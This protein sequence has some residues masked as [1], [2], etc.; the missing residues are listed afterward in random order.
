MTGG[1]GLACPDMDIEDPKDLVQEEFV[2]EGYGGHVLF[3]ARRP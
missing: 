3:W 2:P 1:G